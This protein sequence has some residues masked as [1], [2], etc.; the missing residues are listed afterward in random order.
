MSKSKLLFD[1]IMYVNTKRN[2]T[3]QDVAYEFNI[4]VRTAH[5][6]L[7]EL[8]EMGVPL[9]T[10]PGRNG[11]YRILNNRVLPPI[12]FD[13]DEAFSIFYAFQ[14]LKYYQSLPFDINI[15]SVSRKLYASLPSDVR[16]K[17]DRLDSILSFW[18]IKRSVPSPY[19]KEIIEAASEN[20]IISIEYMSK[21]KNTTREIAPVGVYS[22]DGFWYMPAFDLLR[23]EIRVFRL[24]RIL[25][26]ESLQKK[27]D[28]QI[29]LIDWLDNHTAQKTND[30]I[31]L[32]VELTREG[33]RQ[34]SSQVW[35]ESHIIITNEAHG[36]IDIEIDKCE[37]EF[38]TKFFYQLGT[39][40]KVIEPREI[41]DNIRK[42]SQ[43]IL[44]HYS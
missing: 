9:Y 23:N 10:E 29:S 30:T 41:I 5:R 7:L 19:L 28:P 32:Y 1:L 27:Y 37:I 2:F 40:A 16:K 12:I 25:S 26:L 3:A 31:R 44:M 39:N 20:Q 15:N 22:Y 36:F 42:Q 14:A 34:C 6:Y 21:S 17:I 13:E 24:D 8:S 38:V 18:N 43:D 33:M 35:L 11:G 4:S